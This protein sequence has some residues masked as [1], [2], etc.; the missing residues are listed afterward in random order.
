MSNSTIKRGSKLTVT[1]DKGITNLTNTNN[2]GI[3]EISGPVMTDISDSFKLTSI[4]NANLPQL[5][6]GTTDSSGS[7]QLG[8]FKNSNNKTL[9]ILQSSFDSSTGDNDNVKGYNHLTLQPKGGN[10]GIRTNDPLAI[11]DINN[12]LLIDPVIGYQTDIGHNVYDSDGLGS[13]KNIFQGPSSQIQLAGGQHNQAYISFRL[14]NTNN[15][16]ST[17]AGI[18]AQIT[19]A[20]RIIQG[21]NIGIGT[22]NPLARF[23][24]KSQNRYISIMDSG[25]NNWTE[26]RAH[27][28]T[29][30]NSYSWL[31]LSSMKTVFKTNGS[32]RMIINSDGNVGIGTTSPGGKLT[33]Y[34]DD[35]E[36]T[37]SKLLLKVQDKVAENEWTGIG[38]GGYNQTSKSAIIHERTAL[39][40]RGNLHFCQN[41]VSDD[42]DVTKSDS[43]MTI[44]YSGNVGIGTTNPDKILHIH[45]SSSSGNG[46]YI[47]N[48]DADSN[49]M[50]YF[51]NSHS[52]YGL[53]LQEYDNNHGF[54]SNILTIEKGT[55][56]VGIGTNNPGTLLHIHGGDTGTS[57]FNDVVLK[58]TGQSDNNY[59]SVG[60]LFN[61]RSEA[62]GAKAGIFG[63][64]YAGTWNRASLAF[65]TNNE[66]NS[67]DASISDVKMVIRET[68]NVGIG[69]SSPGTL[70]H[71]HKTTLGQNAGGSEV[72]GNKVR[73]KITGTNDHAS[74]GIELYE[75]NSNETGSGAVLKYDGQANDFKINVW[76]GG[77]EREAISIPRETGNVIINPANSDNNGL[78]VYKSSGGTLGNP[79]GTIFFRYN[80]S[81]S[82]GAISA[83]DEA[84]SGSYNGGLNF[85]TWN[86]TASAPSPGLEGSGSSGT[87]ALVER[88]RIDKNGNVGINTTTPAFLLNIHT[89]SAN[90][91]LYISNPNA[92]SSGM[93][94]LFN[95]HSTYGLVLQEYDSDDVFLRNIMT[96]KKEN[97]N[98]GI[99]TN[100]PE[101]LLDIYKDITNSHTTIPGN[102]NVTSLPNTTSLFIG[103][104][105]NYWG[106]AMGN[107]WN[108]PSYIQ[109]TFT[110]SSSYSLLLQPSGG[111]VG[112]GTTNPGAPLHIYTS[113]EVA[114]KIRGDSDTLLL[115]EGGGG[116]DGSDGP[117]WD[118]VGVVIKGRPD[119]GYWLAGTDDSSNYQIKYHSSGYNFDT[120]S[121]FF[122]VTTDGK[123]GIGTNTPRAKF[124]VNGSTSLSESTVSSYTNDYND[125]RVTAGPYNHDGYDM[126]SSK[127]FSII[128]SHSIAC[129]SVVAFSDRR[130]K[131]EIRDV[132]DNLS[133]QTLR[134]INCVYYKYKDHIKKGN[135]DTIG[136]IAQQVKEHMP[137]VVNTMK[138]IIPNE[139]RNIND[140]SWNTILYDNNDNLITERIYDQ[141]GNDI[142]KEKYKL[143]IHDLSYNSG[144]IEHRFYVSNDPSGNDECEKN[145]FS[146][147]GD[148]KSFIFEETWNHIFLYGYEV[149]DFHTLDKQKLMAVNF[150]AT[151]EIDKQQQADKLRIATLEA[152]VASLKTKNQ[153][154]E[155]E[156]DAIKQYL[157]L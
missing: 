43:K 131:K 141:S 125:G 106:I 154:L 58:L 16:T 88:M 47:S 20:L 59:G 50:N 66:G 144:N 152:E 101:T 48:P 149:N 27:D 94:Y 140:Y 83:L 138:S 124:H 10:L 156:I 122:S 11:F 78:Y 53:I 25:E 143:T 123:V 22:T 127:A 71:I 117:E 129:Q 44:D 42:T 97:G 19:E 68:G 130:I 30:I 69:T 155:Q 116:G 6:I 8:V 118:E 37:A 148:Y 76:N 157:G 151:Q 4:T 115:I 77:T 56:N 102:I 38:L 121:A 142:T 51:F 91:G 1:T 114:M 31:F 61:M 57:T 12:M 75:D 74:P 128:S 2:I 80:S 14:S 29:A 17:P 49:G 46:L 55:G 84:G 60:I 24:V 103:E 110:G 120:A 93:N 64:D 33:I 28:D 81:Y 54:K 98:V 7:L 136:F 70:L 89:P 34:G 126:T 99:N 26:I 135:G 35:S 90:N 108:G 104:T 9:S 23:T 15:D 139:M 73:L 109:T 85:W 95:S 45:S 5:R 86:R 52:T 67:N 111:N 147:H 132:P 150:S 153:S 107:I 96:F 92:N 32:E 79:G 36:S 100:N 145:I 65:C 62:S 39:Y 40:G 137:M 21:G 41:N 3:A 119:G 63:K 13:Y 134:N 146:L 18:D 105:H 133:L 113:A 112:I 87:G 72:A 82:A